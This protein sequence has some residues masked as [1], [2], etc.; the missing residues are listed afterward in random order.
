MTLHKQDK[1]NTIH[2]YGLD[3]EN[4]EIYLHSY[5][6]SNEEESGVDYRSAINL[7]KNIRY[8]NMINDEPIIIHMNI[9]GGSWE[10]C[11]AMYD[12]IRLSKAKIGIIAYGK[13]QSASSIILQSAKLRILMPNVTTLIHYGSLSFDNE[14]K[15]AIS[16]MQ[17]S[18]KESNKMIDIFTEKCL[19]SPLAKIKNWRKTNIKKHILS[20]L[21]SK[22]DWILNAEQTID[23]GFADGIM[24]TQGF[25][26]MEQIKRKLKNNK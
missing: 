16:N 3:D 14:H 19:H 21:D 26:T 2:E 15:A 25:M 6:D 18:E 20:Q 4:R 9:P 11:L 7:I 10:D 1:I 17:W 12:V 24:G 8:L 5:I 23:Y 22:S 13:V